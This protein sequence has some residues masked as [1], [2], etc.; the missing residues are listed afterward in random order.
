MK[1]SSVVVI[2]PVVNA[3]VLFEHLD[4]HTSIPEQ[5]PEPTEL[6]LQEERHEAAPQIQISFG[7]YFT[8]LP[9]EQK[10][11]CYMYQAR[12]KI[13]IPC[14]CPKFVTAYHMKTV[15]K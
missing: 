15:V 9:A 3:T 8:H 10:L 12:P 7:K 2:E 1:I 14:W 13:G 4:R 6:H 5:S 11:L